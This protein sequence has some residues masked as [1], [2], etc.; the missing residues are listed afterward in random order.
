MASL[1]KTFYF[2]PYSVS[3]TNSFLFLV[4]SGNPCLL[5]STSY[6]WNSFKR[7]ISRHISSNSPIWD[8][9][10]GYSLWGLAYQWDFFFSFLLAICW[11]RPKSP[12]HKKDF[13]SFLRPLRPSMLHAPDIYFEGPMWLSGYTCRLQAS[14]A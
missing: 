13:N 4:D 6:Y 14:G 9:S 2:H 8:N 7:E 10:F 1:H 12:L 3:F 5:Y 11:P